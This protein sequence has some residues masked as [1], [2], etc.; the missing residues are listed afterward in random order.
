M[1][2]WNP[3]RKAERK[4][5]PLES[6]EVLWRLDPEAPGYLGTL[7]LSA[8]NNPDGMLHVSPEHVEQVR[9]YERRYDD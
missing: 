7:H 8:T 2:F 6:A 5:V 9:A 4:L 3:R 1:R